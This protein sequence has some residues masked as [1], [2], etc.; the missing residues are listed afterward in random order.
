MLLKLISYGLNVDFSLGIFSL[1]AFK[2]VGTLL[3]KSSKTL[4]IFF[5]F[6]ALELCNKICDHVTNFAH[7]L[8][9]YILNCLLGEVCKLL[10]CSYTVVHNTCGVGNID[11]LAELINLLELFCCE[12]CLKCDVSV[13]LLCLRCCLFCCSCRCFCCLSLCSETK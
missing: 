5:N 3:E 8:G 12:L 13:C 9:S 6:K 1:H 4:L 7:V 11:L 10:L 2:L